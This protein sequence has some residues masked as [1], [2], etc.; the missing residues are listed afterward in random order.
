MGGVLLGFYEP[1]EWSNSEPLIYKDLQLCGGWPQN[2]ISLRQCSVSGCRYSHVT[3]VWEVLGNML[4]ALPKSWMTFIASSLLLVP[5]MMLGQSVTG[6]LVGT[7]Y[8]ASGAAVTG[9]A[10]TAT[11]TQTGV[12]ASA[13][14]ASTGQY[15]LGNLSV[16]T[17]D[18]KVTAAG[19]NVAQLKNLAVSL[20][21]TSTAN[22]NLQVGEAKTI[23]EVSATAATIDTTT[24]QV[25]STFESRQLSDL[26]TASSGSGVLN[27]A[28]LTAGVS[29]SGT[30]GVGAGPSVGGQRPRNNNFTIEGVDNNS[31][32][33]TG[34]LA[35]LPNDT[36]AEFSILQNQFSAQ[37]G[38]SS[39]GQFNQIV[40]SGTNS[41]HGGAYE[42]MFN[43][44]LNAADNLSIVQGVDPH[45]RFDNNR[46]G[47]Y[48]GG[49]IKRNKLFFFGSYEYNPVG[50]TGTP[51]VVYAPTTAG[52]QTLA[53]LP[54]V[55][56]TNL[57]LLQ[58]YLPAQSTA[59]NPSVTPNGE[60]PVVGGKVIP[61]GQFSFLA[62]K[63]TNFYT[64][65]ASADYTISDKD[66]LRGRF[67]RNNS[68]GQD[69][70]ASLP[71]FWVPLVQPN[72][73]AT[74]TEFHN[75]TPSLNNEF[76]L[77]F[78]RFAQV[79]QVGPQKAPG[80][81][82]F[83]NLT[84]DEL[85]INVG[86]DPNAPQETIQNL[87]QV[88]D[89]V[90]FVK[91][92]HT[93]QFGGDFRKYISPQSF[94]QRG[95]GDYE[96]DTLTNFL[97]DNIPYFA[98]RTTGNFIYYGDQ[99]LFGTYANDQWKIRQNVTLNLGL[100]WERTTIPY[101]E[102]LQTINSISS[103]PGLINFGEPKV[104][105]NNFQ[106]R[107]GIAYSP[108]KSGTTSIR[109]GFGIN[110]DKLFDNLGILSAAPQFQQT[111]DVGVD[112]DTSGNFL[113]TGGIP[114]NASSVG[115]TQA[116]ARA[117][118]GGFIPD[119]KL[120]KS[121]QWNLGVQRVFHDNYTVEV[122][123]LGT[124]GL[125]LPIQDRINVRSVVNPQN[126][127]PTYLTAPSQATLDGLTNTLAGLTNAYNTP[128]AGQGRFLPQYL[129]AGFKTN[130]V[131]FMPMGASTYHGLSLQV[132]R[133]FSNGLQF[134]GAYTYSHN[135]DNST[136]EVFSTFTNPRRVQDFQNLNAER[137]SSALD[138]RNRFTMAT[139]Y[140][141]P[142]FKHGGNWFTR[143]L[144][145]NWEMAPVF[146][147]ETGTLVTP[148]SAV[149]AN[150]N[151]DSAGD[152]TIFNP[153]GTANVGSG[154]TALKNTAGAT[155][156]YLANN[157]NARYIQ[158]R[159]GA[160]ATAGRQTQHLMPIDNID[161]TMLKRFDV[162]K[163]GYKLEFGARFFNLLNHAQYTGSNISDVA[164]V[165]YTGADV[166]NFLN[167]S[168]TTF[169]RPDQV[170][171][172]NP[173]TIQLSAKFTF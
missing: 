41:F 6:E 138:H 92:K 4:R 36:V 48:L 50:Q 96:W 58:Q 105:N 128:G 167:P 7:V 165:G 67:V 2:C 132:N 112:G 98:E 57:S 158:A 55:S 153:A 120:P 83:P 81:D 111:V 22:V 89:N 71:Q 68:A 121:L 141:L 93:F 86:P 33:V 117:A 52:Y 32:S 82:A 44:N 107:I 25:Q 17:Y 47:G 18:L 66:Q 69:T 173:R 90:T 10:V 76:R 26:P 16:G 113:K 24:A 54:G 154:V 139:L 87:Y 110:Y 99:V 97:Q 122:R 144:I 59:V 146:T 168:S 13:T 124:R 39:G 42:Y 156:A 116:Q 127:L 91:G 35:S 51:G 37:Y 38:A 106:P 94:T 84:I 108:G 134:V 150:L 118:T 56:Q 164:S 77:G 147:Y 133:R 8:D 80:L 46:F 115:L 125:N 163:E 12:M 34:P 162:F 19:F 29:S 78:N 157:P 95:R 143:N 137:A 142:F 70:A 148:Q 62:P 49:P 155:V 152:R 103:V 149:D 61:L 75:F 79:F 145:G 85:G 9:A 131:G 45:P 166:H 88:T 21:T 15:R 129:A 72:Y 40:K 27:L 160:L 1:L 20:N 65:I 11:N 170:F 60:F 119:Q 73:F 74:L 100:R 104:Q 169:Y 102:R 151:G 172:S 28:L 171:S 161:F 31:K 23:V 43:R 30:T 64:W 159:S 135:I 136:A 130:I 53:S 5:S 63:F 101:G 14:T 114:N 109:A 140:D 126:A 3:N 123:Y